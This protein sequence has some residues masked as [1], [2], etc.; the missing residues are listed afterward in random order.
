[1]DEMVENDDILEQM[2]DKMLTF[3]LFCNKMF[4][5]NGDMRFCNKMLLKMV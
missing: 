4:W 2:F 5:A 3:V 1:M